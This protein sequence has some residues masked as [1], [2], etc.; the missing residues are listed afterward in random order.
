MNFLQ[1]L[2]INGLS[3]TCATP[4]VAHYPQRLDRFCRFAIM[5]LDCAFHF[6]AAGG[7]RDAIRRAFPAK[8]GR[9][10][11]TLMQC[12]NMQQKAASRSTKIISRKRRKP[13]WTARP[14][15]PPFW[16]VRSTRAPSSDG[17]FFFNH[18]SNTGYPPTV[19]HPVWHIKENPAAEPL[20]QG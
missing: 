15:K 17:A 14:R 3:I 7:N 5:A 11:P 18:L 8:K 1:N 13:R 12:R 20:S 2:W 19:P 10:D 16:E 4:G 6:G 9:S